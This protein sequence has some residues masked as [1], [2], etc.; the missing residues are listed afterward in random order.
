MIVGLESINYTILEGYLVEVCFFAQGDLAK[1]AKVTI[2]TKV[3]AFTTM[4]KFIDKNVPQNIMII[5]DFACI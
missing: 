5:N 2:S 4:G 1:M 3:E